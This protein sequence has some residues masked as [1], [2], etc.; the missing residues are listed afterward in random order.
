MEVIPE[1]TAFLGDSVLHFLALE[2]RPTNPQQWVHHYGSN[3]FLSRVYDEIKGD[4]PIDIPLGYKRKSRK[5][6]I[7][8][9]HLKGT[10]VE[11]W[12]GEA[13]LSGGMDGVIQVWERMMTIIGN[14]KYRS[15]NHFNRITKSGK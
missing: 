10:W 15:R 13:Y 6:R 1:Q 12:L 14:H 5:N 7:H 2:Y 11:T 4:G 3:K 8:I 9:Q